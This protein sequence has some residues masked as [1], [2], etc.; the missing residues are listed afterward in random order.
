MSDYKLTRDAEGNLTTQYSQML[1]DK[2]HYPVVEKVTE[3]EDGSGR[4]DG[5]IKGETKRC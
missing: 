4:C 2:K 1:S 3:H 5:Y